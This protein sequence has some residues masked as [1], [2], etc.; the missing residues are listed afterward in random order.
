MIVTK[1]VLKLLDNA[2][3]LGAAPIVIL[4]PNGVGKTQLS[5]RLAQHNQAERIAALRQIELDEIPLQTFEVAS[6]ETRN[7]LN[8]LLGNWWNQSQEIRALMAEIIGED[9]QA[10]VD[11]RELKE[12]DPLAT[13]PDNLVNTRHKRITKLWNKLFPGREIKLSYRPT[14][15]RATG[16][17][18]STYSTARMSEGERTAL[19]LAARVMSCKTSLLFVDEPETYFHPL[20]AR[21]L[22]N[23]LEAAMPAVR[24]VYITHDI[25]FA[26]SRRAPKFLIAQSESQVEVLDGTDGI[27]PDIVAEVL[28]A[29]S[30]SVSASRLVFCEGEEGGIDKRFYS[31]W[32][33][34]PETAVIPVGSCTAVRECVSVFRAGRATTNV[35]ALGQVDRDAWPEAHLG[36]DAYVK[37]LPVSEIEAV[38][39]IKPIFVALAGYYGLDAADAAIRYDAFLTAARAAVSGIVFNK[40]VLNRARARIELEQRSVHNQLRPSPDLSAMR[41]AFVATAP[42][43]GWAGHLQTVFDEEEQRLR[44]ALSGAPDEFLRFFPAKAYHSHAAHQLNVHPEAILRDLEKAL[45]LPNTQVESEQR[46]AVLRTAV[47]GALSPHLWPRTR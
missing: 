23:E 33:N 32:Y 11:F 16:G 5:V 3:I 42:T 15:T 20:L 28:G 31:A 37:P 36:E 22:W 7:M 45:R 10:A 27:P 4:G 41:T 2:E 26:L 47:V 17:S 14:V 24:F 13:V 44:L 39:C 18:T 34:C 9:R 43:G 8:Q 25:P 1:M 12:A 40:E 19:Y 35:E 30:F 46:L 6:N 21:Q 38:A 29:A